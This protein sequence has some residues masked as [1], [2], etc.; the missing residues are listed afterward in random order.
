[1]RRL[2]FL[3]AVVLFASGCTT[4]RTPTA[5]TVKELIAQSVATVKKFDKTEKI[6]RYREYMEGAAG[7]MVLPAVLK[8]S[9]FG[10]AEAGDGVLL[11]RKPGG[12][13][14]DPTFHTLVA[15]SIGL[16]LGV[17]DSAIILILRSEKAVNSVIRHQGKFGAD[18]GAAAVFTGI[19]AEASTTSNLGADIIAIAQPN[20]G[21]Y[22]GGSLEG[23]VMVTRRDYNE[24]VYGKGATPD[25]IL[26]GQVRTG[27]ADGLKQALGP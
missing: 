24:I 18:I 6:K 16:Q 12:G 21:A 17:Q 27:L 25:A 19:G 13:W 15:G 4:T 3:L 8:V 14:T 20:I 2:A 10:G 5:D 22:I 26:A 23:A 11:K 9:W 1:M 7:V